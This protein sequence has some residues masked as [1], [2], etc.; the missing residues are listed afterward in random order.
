MRIVIATMLM[1]F[2]LLTLLGNTEG[3]GIRRDCNQLVRCLMD[4]CLNSPCGAFETCTS[5]NCAPVCS[6]DPP[7]PRMQRQDLSDLWD[8]PLAKKPRKDDD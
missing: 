6:G 5:C 7:L 2:C 1:A 4:P 3:L 8:F